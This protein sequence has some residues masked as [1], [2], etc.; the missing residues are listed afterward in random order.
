MKNRLPVP[1]PASFGAHS[2]RQNGKSSAHSCNLLLPIW[3]LSSISREG[4]RD[5]Q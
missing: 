4:M 2:C 1:I 5:E 3:V